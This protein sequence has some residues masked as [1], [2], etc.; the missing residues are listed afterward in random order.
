VA[1]DGDHAHRGQDH[2]RR[3]VGDPESLL[4]VRERGR[5]GDDDRG[6]Q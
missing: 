3:L 5:E 2:Q 1:D 4:S 6:G